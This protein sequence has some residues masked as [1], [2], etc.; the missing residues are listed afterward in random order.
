MASY[1]LDIAKYADSQEKVK[2]RSI[3]DAIP[4]QLDDKNRRFVVADLGKEARYRRYESSF[5]WLADAGVVLPCYNV[6]EPKVP[7]AAN[8]KYSLFRLFMSDYGLLS[9][10]FL[11][12]SQLDLLNGNLEANMSAVMKTWL[13]KN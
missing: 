13:R 1:R 12:N 10:S 3:F 2:I 4:S 9:A 8:E 11:G 7:L 5:L 6:A